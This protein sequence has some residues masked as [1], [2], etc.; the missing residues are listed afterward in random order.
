MLFNLGEQQAHRGGTF[1]GL[2]PLAS[3]YAAQPR[4]PGRAGHCLRPRSLA[5]LR[6]LVEGPG[7]LITKGE[8]HQTVWAGTHLTNS[9]L[10]VCVQEI[11][12]ALGDSAAA[13]QYLETVGRQGYRLVVDGALDAPTAPATGPIVGRERNRSVGALVPARRPWRPSTRLCQWRSGGRQDD[14]VDLWLVQQDSGSG[15]QVA[16]ENPICQA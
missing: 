6:Y 8:L 16:R 9:V 1:S 10:R 2:W 3:G 14:R 11:R 12:A 13:P 5:M 15:V 4:V 7:R